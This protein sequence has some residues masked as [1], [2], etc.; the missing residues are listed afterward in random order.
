MKDHSPEDN[1]LYKS[2]VGSEGSQEEKS[3]R[4]RILQKQLNKSGSFY[5]ILLLINPMKRPK[6]LSLNTN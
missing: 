3:A 5:V 4:R 1:N 2:A 6:S